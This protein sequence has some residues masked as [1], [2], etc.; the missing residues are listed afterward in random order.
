MVT[1][2]IMQATLYEIFEWEATLIIKSVANE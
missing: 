1:H 2:I